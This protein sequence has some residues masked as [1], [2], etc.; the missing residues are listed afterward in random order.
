M[1][2]RTEAVSYVQHSTDEHNRNNISEGVSYNG[3]ETERIAEVGEHL[4]R[5]SNPSLL[6]KCGQLQE[7]AQD[8]VWLGFENVHR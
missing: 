3:K 6:L 4:W 2:T 1:F 8:H 5:A 7:P